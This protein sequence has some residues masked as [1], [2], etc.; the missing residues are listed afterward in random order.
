MKDIPSR[1][2]VNFKKTGIFIFFVVSMNIVGCSH[3][4]HGNFCGPGHPDFKG[5]HDEQLVKLIELQ[6]VDDIDY[7][8]KRHDIC[9]FLEYYFSKECDNFIFYEIENI[10]PVVVNEK[11]KNYCDWVRED[12][13]RIVGLY[14]SAWLNPEM[15]GESGSKILYP[16]N[17]MPFQATSILLS[18]PA[19][20]FGGLRYSE[21]EKYDKEHICNDEKQATKINNCIFDILLIGK[22]YNE[23]IIDKHHYNEMVGKYPDI[24]NNSYPIGGTADIFAH[25]IL[26]IKL[27]K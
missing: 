17:E 24:C 12:F 21:K 10:K 15:L 27:K 9:V 22:L 1:L 14:N 16:V 26:K 3:P 23:N 5:T 20:F 25:P 4:V 19:Y 6:P 2:F 13:Q 11:N 8:C 18:G 7:A